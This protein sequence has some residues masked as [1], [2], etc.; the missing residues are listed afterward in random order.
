MTSLHPYNNNF[1]FL[2]CNRCKTAAFVGHLSGRVRPTDRR[3]R[4]RPRKS[5]HSYIDMHS[6]SASNKPTGGHRRRRRVTISR[7]RNQHQTNAKCKS[8]TRT[9]FSATANSFL[10][11]FNYETQEPRSQHLSSNIEQTQASVSWITLKNAH[12][13]GFVQ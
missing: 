9:V 5:G 1:S 13:L 7:R 12:V 10:V 11:V 3:Q 8:N 2:I 4:N 6:R